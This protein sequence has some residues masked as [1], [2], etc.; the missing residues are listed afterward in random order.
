MNRCRVDYGPAGLLLVSIIVFGCIVLCP[1][2]NLL[3]LLSSIISKW[4]SWLA[5]L[6]WNW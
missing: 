1:R 6:F 5:L 2:T 4:W 3:E